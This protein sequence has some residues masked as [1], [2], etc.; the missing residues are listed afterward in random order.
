MQE[1]PEDIEFMQRVLDRSYELAGEHLA[2]IHVPARRLRAEQVADR[3]DGMVLMALATATADGRPLTGAVDGFL[4]RGRV[5]FGS[6]PDSVRLRHVRRRPHVSA[7]HVPVEEFAVTVHGRARL[8]DFDDDEDP[9]APALRQ[10]CLEWYGEDWLRWGLAS[11][12]AAIEP[13]RMFAFHLD[14]DEDRYAHL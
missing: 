9:V 11:R 3:L 8:L 4:V 7:T 13:D 12:Y 2:S 14:D 5:C 1:R 10:A 6:S